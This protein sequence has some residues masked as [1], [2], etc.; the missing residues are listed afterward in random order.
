MAMPDEARD[1]LPQRKRK[2]LMAVL[3]FEHVGKI[4]GFLKNKRI[5]V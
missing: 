2:A 1:L 3:F 5:G 4:P